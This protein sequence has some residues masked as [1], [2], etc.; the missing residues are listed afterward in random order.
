MPCGPVGSANTADPSSRAQ[1]EVDVAAIA[2]ALIVF[3]HER[4]ALAVPVGD[5]LGAVL[6][7][8]VVVAGDQRVVVTEPDL[9][10]APVA[11]A[12]DGLTV[13]ARALHAEP[14]V[15][16]QRLHS[17][18][19]QYRVV[20]VVVAGRGQPAV[21]ARP[22]LPVGVV[23][24]DELELGGD[25]G[26]P[27]PLGRGGPV[28]RRRMLRGAAATALPSRQPRSAITS[29]VP[30]SQGSSRRVSGPASSPCRRN[31]CPSWTSHSRARCSFSTSTASR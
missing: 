6:V 27:A 14:D 5:F 12:L 25:V 9:L 16:Q 19:R 13:Q 30:G 29:A 3:R 31:R 17:R 22:R 2:F 8:G 28:G 23:E 11:L 1:R 21:A 15:A 4:Q 20:D 10:L 24:D 7:D 18:R 26:R